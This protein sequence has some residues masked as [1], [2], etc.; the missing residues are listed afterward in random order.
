MEVK[1]PNTHN[2]STTMTN[3][4]KQHPFYTHPISLG[5]AA[6]GHLPVMD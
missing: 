6:D 5:N 2:A 3:W 1:L 4:V